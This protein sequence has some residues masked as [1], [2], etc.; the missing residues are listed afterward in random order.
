MHLDIADVA[1]VDQMK[2]MVQ[3]GYGIGWFRLARIKKNL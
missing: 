2:C 1:T 3:N